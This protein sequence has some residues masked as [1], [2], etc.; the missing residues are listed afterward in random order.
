MS[1]SLVA[2]TIICGIVAVG[3]LVGFLARFH[4]KMD[5][6]QWTVGGRGFGLLLVWVLMAG[7]IH[8]IHI[9]WGQ[10]LGV[11]EGRSRPLHPGI[12]PID[13]CSFVLHPPP[14]LEVG[15]KHRL[16]TQ[17]DFFQVRYGSHYLGAFVALMELWP[18]PSRANTSHWFGDDRGD[19]ELWSDHRTPAMIIGFALVAGFV[20]VSG[21]RGV[22][23]VSLIKDLLLLI[24]AIFIGIAVPRIYFGGIG[25]MFAALAQTNPTHLVMPG[26][27]KD[28]GHLPVRDNGFDDFLRLLH[29]AAIF[30]CQLY[31]A[32]RQNLRRNA[33]I[34][35]LYA[36]TM[37]LMFFVGLSAFLILPGL[38]SGDLSMLRLCARH[39][40]RG[41]WG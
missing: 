7:E 40:R 16:Q 41:F 5:L 30:R 38:S 33:V 29:V 26:A 10:R 36:I 18:H 22:A 6:E 3:S 13:L 39:S 8:H 11:F 27:T 23:W 32:E 17:A 28:L 2:L 15:R 37:P 24:A 19:C 12:Q 35:P 9:L 20:F 1:P 25:P 31:R 14:Y 4:R 34:M 21:V